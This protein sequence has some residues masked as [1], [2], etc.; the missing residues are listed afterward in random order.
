[1]NPSQGSF[2]KCF[3]QWLRS[4]LLLWVL[5][6]PQFAGAAVRDG[7]WVA[8]G[9]VYAGAVFGTHTGGATGGGVV[10]D[11]ATVLLDSSYPVI[12]GQVHAVVADG[13]GGWFVGGQFSTAGAFARNNL[14]HIRPDRSV[15]ALWDP[16]PDGIVRA[17]VLSADGQT[18]YVGGDFSAIAGENRSR[19]AALDT[20]SAVAAAWN[21][22]A[23]GA[24]RT[25]VLS[26]DGGALYIGGDFTTVA[27]TARSRLAAV[28][29]ADGTPLS[30]WQADADATVHALALGG[31]RLYVGGAFTNLG[32][33]SRGRLAAVDAASGAVA[34]WDAAADGMV[35]ALAFSASDGLLYAGGDFTVIGGAA[36]SRIAAL[37]TDAINPDRATGW[38]PAAD[39]AVHTLLLADG[40][41][42]VG[43]DFT[44]IGG[45]GRSRIAAL[46]TTVD[47]NNASAWDPGLDG[48]ALALAINSGRLYVGGVF[49]G[50]SDHATLFIGGDFAYVG[51]VTG[52]GVGLP[53][54]PAV[55]GDDRPLS[56]YPV[57]NGTVH[58]VLADGAGGWYIGGDFSTVGG[59]VRSNIAH[60]NSDLSVDVAWD[61]AADGM[62]HALA[63]AGGTVYAA[64]DFT[65]IGGQARNRIAALDGSGTA[66]AWNPDAD[67]TVRALL[68][69]G[70]TVYVGGDFT[71]IGGAARNRIAALDGSGAATVWNPDA[72]GT[73][74]ALVLG[75]DGTTLFVGGDFS[76]IGG[77]LRNCIAAL[78]G[79][80][81]VTAWDPGADG[82]VRSLRMSGTT[83]YVGGDF[84]VIG[85]VSRYRL[86]AL[87]ADPALPADAAAS[88][89]N[90]R[91]GGNVHAL[92]LD[93]VTLYAGGAFASAGG[94]LRSRIAALGL[95]DGSLAS[96]NPGADGAVRT[97][98]FS[99]AGTTLYVGGEFSVIGGQQRKGVAELDRVTGLAN[100]WDPAADGPVF[101]LEVA[102]DGSAIYAAGSF[103]VIGGQ[104]RPLLAELR[105]NGSA[106]QWQPAISGSSVTPATSG[107]VYSLWLDG[108]TLY[109]G[110][111]FARVAELDHKGIVA[112]DI[113][114]AAPRD[115]APQVEG[116]VRTLALYK[117]QGTLYI[118]GTFTAVGGDSRL[119]LA[120]LDTDSALAT[121]W[122][123][124]ADGAVRGL[125]LAR[126]RASVYVGGDFTLVGGAARSRLAA[127]DIA[128]ASALPAWT[129]GADAAV[130]FLQLAADGGVLYSGGAFTRLDDAPRPALAALDAIPLERD[131]PLTTATPPPGA[132]NSDSNQPVVLSCDDG[133]GSGCA[134]TYYT[135][136]G[137]APTTRSLR[138]SDPI[139]LQADTV[140]RYFSVDRL[141]NT[142]TPVSAVYS[143][144]L[145][146]PQTIASPASMVFS[147][148]HISVTLSCSDSQSGCADTFY[149][150]DENAPPAAFVLYQ[151]PIRISDNTVL[152]FFSV[153]QA[154]NQ[155]VV[156]R[157]DYISNYGGPGGLHPLWLL[158]LLAGLWRRMP[159]RL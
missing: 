54:D 17:L 83:L 137:S 61:P 46:D 76:A 114:S 91:A 72:D 150:K 144:E 25:L 93:G 5:L 152:R 53:A 112:L 35:Q 37:D 120:A 107:A 98:S 122:N 156:R 13:A 109:A 29:V 128:D 24:V 108:A 69:S 40:L 105:P 158:L 138:F 43:G 18:L 96:W 89:W 84:A 47:S 60:I 48:T 32:G 145:L 110:G 8:D 81:A 126:D 155:E 62:V 63:L 143:L 49:N 68:V 103:G 116:V 130:F 10:I 38:D 23:D 9:P 55:P 80:G 129:H 22:G 124:Q 142:E 101:A 88:V 1:M 39:G 127:L 149:S 131:A 71:T 74:H 133:K 121:S 125:V 87:N 147:E 50:V 75:S 11:T 117:E 111:D 99:P 115:W 134:A 86:A 14:L 100:F 44:N 106:T 92:A 154:G 148:R 146:A 6:L 119:N 82:A 104:Q 132:Y 141:G 102:D 66:T 30:G 31:G 57:V 65:T 41:L 90:P 79:S 136:D 51:P 95:N 151:G 97:M 113:T 34:S 153:D 56:G 59:V 27:A 15:D 7:L 73:V 21:P 42:Y 52:A 12:N 64:G 20:A 36:R 3:L 135:L 4:C 58:A 139:E 2:H 33:Q 70:A 45:A 78:D 67:G 77:A 85:G 16:A 123:P 94:E 118:G 28:S 159:G 140:I 26:A 157:E 19:L